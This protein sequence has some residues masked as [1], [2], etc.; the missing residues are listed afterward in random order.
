M[1]DYIIL[2][3]AS[4]CVLGTVSDASAL[5]MNKTIRY[6]IHEDPQDPQSTVIYHVEVDLT[7]VDS[8]PEAIAW[9]V[10]E[11]RITK[12]DSNGDITWTETSPA[13]D[14]SDGNWWVK[15]ADLQNPQ[16]SEFTVPELIDGTAAPD[17]QG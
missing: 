4:V 11:I 17:V 16:L 13:V 12:K 6:T 14:S 2:G 8:D 10:L 3:L 9:E 1:R 15:H 7:D 5:A